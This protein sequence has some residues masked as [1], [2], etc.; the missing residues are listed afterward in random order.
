MD[1][2]AA[3]FSRR[4]RAALG[5]RVRQLILFGSRARGDA[6]EGSDYDVLLVVD[7]SPRQAREVVLDVEAHMLDR[8]GVLFAAIVRSEQEWRDCEGF[9]LAMNIAREGIAL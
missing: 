9:P 8:Y 1:P 6:R 2:I 7:D 3:E 4:L 5:E